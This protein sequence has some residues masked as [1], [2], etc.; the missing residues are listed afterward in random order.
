MV[1]M[2]QGSLVFAGRPPNLTIEEGGQQSGP[3][4]TEILIG[5]VTGPRNGD[6]AGQFFFGFAS[7]PR[8]LARESGAL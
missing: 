7:N 6:F 1:G 3:A 5:D 8:N 2:A 4:Q